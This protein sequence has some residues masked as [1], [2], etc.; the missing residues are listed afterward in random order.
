MQD[1]I[2]RDNVAGR[3]LSMTWPSLWRRHFGTIAS[4][5]DTARIVSDGDRSNIT[6]RAAVGY[7]MPKVELHGFI[8]DLFRSC[9][10]A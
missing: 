3:E 8:V 5:S 4:P 9:H 1:E 7:D 2:V 10:T 6:M